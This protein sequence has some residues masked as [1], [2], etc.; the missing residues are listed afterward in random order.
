MLK[1]KVNPQ[2]LRKPMATLKM[3]KLT[4]SL[5]AIVIVTLSMVLGEALL[6]TAPLLAA[7]DKCPKA[8]GGGSLIVHYQT[9]SF[10]IS[11]CQGGTGRSDWREFDYYGVDRKRGDGIRLRAYLNPETTDYPNGGSGFYAVNSPYRYTISIHGLTVKRGNSTLLQEP[12]IAC[13]GNESHCP[14]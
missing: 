10:D 12:L 11:I 8:G 9:Q 6:T 5:L 2:Y 1:L 7:P 14:K 3:L 4:R 13:S